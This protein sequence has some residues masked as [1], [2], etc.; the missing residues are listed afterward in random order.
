MIACPFCG[1]VLDVI[2][3]NR[4]AF[5]VYDRHPVSPGHCL[6]IPRAHVSTIFELEEPEYLACFQLLRTIQIKV[7]AT[8]SAAGFNV[9]VNCGQVAGQTI[10]HAHIH[11]IPRYPGDVANPRGG[12]RNVIPG[13]G[14]Y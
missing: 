11:L 2:A 6:I 1:A 9:G 13:K 7:V 5:S 12:V 8:H 14:D 4:F 3:E 10:A